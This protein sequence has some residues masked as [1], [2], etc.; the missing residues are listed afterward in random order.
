M[1]IEKFLKNPDVMV[2]NMAWLGYYRS[3]LKSMG[4]DMTNFDWKNHELNEEAA[5]YAEFMV[6]DQQNMNVAE[7]GG[8]LL[9]SKDAT[10]KII[11]QLLFPFASYQFN[12]KDKN[13]RNLTILTSK[14]S[15]N[16]EKVQAAKSY[17][18][19][20][21]ESYTFQTIQGLIGII[22]LPAA[23]YAI[24]YDQPQEEKTEGILDALA[25]AM[26]FLR[27]KSSSEK[28]NDSLFVGKSIFEFV[29]PLPLPG[30]LESYTLIALNSL[31]D[32]IQG[33]TPKEQA[34]EKKELEK[35]ENTLFG[36]K[37]K[38]TKKKVFGAPVVDKEAEKLKEKL[39][40]PFRFPVK[41]E[42]PVSQTVGDILGGVPSV[43][44]EAIWD[45]KV[46]ASEAFDGSYEDKFCNVYEYS[47]EQ[48]KIL[49]TSLIPRAMVAMNIAPREFLTI[50]NN[51]VKAVN[52][53]AKE[54]K[55]AKKE[56]EK[57]KVRF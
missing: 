9:A 37:A 8:K 52:Q 55:K 33:G 29:A 30:A 3:K 41:D 23:Y 48:K 7:L 54:D 49:K 11:R 44:I 34:K 12:L 50:S 56:S 15:T 43:G 10:T 28:W 51:I 2:A 13:N 17:A 31:M 42:Q 35:K 47:D 38:R 14:T 24:G 18:S 39:E 45:M 25:K 40:A 20:V 5:D 6:Q 19:G 46:R 57:R 26:P 22:L 21:V 1:Y 53:K 27:S 16:E 4:V 32:I 36:R